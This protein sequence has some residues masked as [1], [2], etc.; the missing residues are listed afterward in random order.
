[1]LEQNRYLSIKLTIHFL[2]I[3]EGRATTCE[4]WGLGLFEVLVARYKISR[5]AKCTLVIY[6]NSV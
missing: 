6:I 4:R 2:S 1:M 5:I 3:P